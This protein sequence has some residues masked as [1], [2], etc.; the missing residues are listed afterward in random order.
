[1]KVFKDQSTAARSVKHPR[2][3]NSKGLRAGIE[4]LRE[5]M[6]PS[7]REEPKHGGLIESKKGR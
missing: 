7:K 3:E 2:P 1:M 5:H 4:H 6:K